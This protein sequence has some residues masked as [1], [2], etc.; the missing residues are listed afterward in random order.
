MVLARTP[1]DQEMAI[2][3]EELV[4]HLERYGKAPADAAKLLAVGERKPKAG[5]KPDEVAAYTLLLSTIL[6]LDETLTRN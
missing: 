2:L 6:N 4:T 3:L 1:T 5:L